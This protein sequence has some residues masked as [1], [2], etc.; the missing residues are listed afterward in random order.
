MKSRWRRSRANVA[1][2]RKEDGLQ[3]AIL[4]KDKRRRYVNRFTDSWES[5]LLGRR[6]NWR[7]LLWIRYCIIAQWRRSAADAH[8]LKIL[9]DAKMQKE[10]GRPASTGVIGLSKPSV[11]SA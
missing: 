8:K 11:S 10:P 3:T 6:G 7:A 9:L 5:P 1:Q 2:F 4:P